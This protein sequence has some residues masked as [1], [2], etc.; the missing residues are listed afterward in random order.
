MRRRRMGVIPMDSHLPKVNPNLHV[1]KDHSSIIE[2]IQGLIKVFKDGHVERLPVMPEVPPSWSSNH[3]VLSKDIVLH[4]S[5]SLWSRFYIPMHHLHHHH[6]LPLLVYFHGGGFCIGSA[7]W[8]CYHEFLSRLALETTSIIL[9]V[10]YRLSP[11]HRLPA[12][13]EDGLTAVKWLRTKAGSEDHALFISHCDLSNVYLAGDSAG[14]AI[15]YH[16]VT[17]LGNNNG[18]MIIKG[19][20]LMQPFFGGEERTNSE[21]MSLEQPMKSALSLPTSDAYWRLSLPPGADRNHRW[22]NPFG[23][24]A[25]KVD[26]PQMKIPSML[27][28]V[29]ELDILKDRNLGFCMALRMAG[30]KVELKVYNGVGHAFQILHQY[31]H[32]SQARTLE[33]I[34]DIKNF[35]FSTR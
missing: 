27:V 12:A 23:R 11:E 21:T 16:V 32:V 35:I 7:A 34:N 9:S 18:N 10:N 15:A 4:P 5:T 26:D 3:D 8:K 22:C 2:E 6:Q 31:S 19:V 25:P 28:C 17:Q 13:Y 1:P 20:I 33:M 30:K 24:G 14:G 29:A